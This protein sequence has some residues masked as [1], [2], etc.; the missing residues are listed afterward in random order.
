MSFNAV[1]LPGFFFIQDELERS[2]THHSNQDLYDRVQ[3]DELKHNAIV[4]AA[5][6]YKTAMRDQRMPR[7]KRPS[8]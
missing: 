3:A 7:R 2:R 6:V 5:L 1:G 4:I 8:A